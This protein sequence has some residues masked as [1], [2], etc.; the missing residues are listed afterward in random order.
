MQRTLQR[1]RRYFI[2]FMVISFLGWAVETI[3][4]L[5]CYGSLYDRGFMTLPFCTIYGFSFLLLYFLIGT[6]DSDEGTLLPKQSRGK[7]VYFLLSSLIPTGLELITGYFFHKVFGIRLWSYSAYRFHFNGYICFEY[8][9]LWGI[10]IPLC[11]KYVFIPLK[12]WVF[13]LPEAF[14]RMLSGSLALLSAI[15]WAINFS[16]QEF[17][18]FINAA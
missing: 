17:M 3:F 6:P 8:A 1:A 4:F 15:D 5:L 16:R 11:M 13:A 12:N 10:L 7:L 18:I 2:L 14:T 9:L